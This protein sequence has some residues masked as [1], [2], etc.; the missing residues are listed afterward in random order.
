MILMLAGTSDARELAVRIHGAGYNLLS[1]V[2]TESAAKSLEE[3]GIPVQIG[4]LDAGG[5]AE[6]IRTRGVQVVVDASHP[7][8]EEASRQAMAAALQSEVPYIR[9]ERERGT[10]EGHPRLIFVDDYEQAAE[11]AA[12]RRGV[13]ML[14]TGSKTLH[15]F[16]ERLIGLP[17]TRLVARM[18]PRKD[19]MDKCEQLG[20]EQKNIVA[21]QGPFS[22]ELN[23]ALY[24]H[25]GVTTVITKESGKIGAVEEKLAAAL[26]MDI[27]TIVIGRPQLDYGVVY[28]E[29]EGVLEELNNTL[30]EVR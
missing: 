14:T 11:L 3:A 9:Y 23:Q 13:I 18:L 21:M 12:E 6:L 29:F 20:V 8:A 4:R 17:D 30:Q 2:V 19:N 15:I 16:A 1:T 22:K 10:Y 5:M 25:Y 26:E 7:F 24:R 28:S 27:D